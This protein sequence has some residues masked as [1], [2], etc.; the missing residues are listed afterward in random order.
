M[1]MGCLSSIPAVRHRYRKCRQSEK[2]GNVTALV[3]NKTV[4][5]K[6]G[7]RGCMRCDAPPCNTY[8]NIFWVLL[9]ILQCYWFSLL[10][11]VLQLGL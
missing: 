4:E 8:C 10:N 6:R 5:M 9:T 3:G 1:L 2:V 7:W 11:L